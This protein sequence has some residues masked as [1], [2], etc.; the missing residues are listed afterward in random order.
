[1]VERETI[2]VG[3]EVML[4]VLSIQTLLRRIVCR[5]TL[6]LGLNLC[7]GDR[8]KQTD[9]RPMTHVDVD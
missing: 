8:R 5:K 6:R 4:E 7:R 9:R 3:S 2:L 1:M